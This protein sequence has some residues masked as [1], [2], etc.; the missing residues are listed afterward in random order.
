MN[1]RRYGYFNEDEEYVP[2]SFS[3]FNKEIIPNL[4]ND[5]NDEDPDAF[6]SK[7]DESHA[8]SDYGGGDFGD[9]KNEEFMVHR[10]YD[11]N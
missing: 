8:F 6:Y 10:E 3:H 1:Q 9:L 2:K 11:Y 7:A 5:M 4:L